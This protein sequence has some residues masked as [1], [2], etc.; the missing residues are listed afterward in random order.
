MHVV[1]ISGSLR[2]KSTSTELLRAA[3]KLVPHGMAI[4]VVRNLDDL[5]HFNPDDDVMPPPEPVEALRS[6]LAGADGVVV[7]CPEYAHGIPGVLKNA[8]DWLV[9]SGELYDKPCALFNPSPRAHHAQD[10]LAEVLRTMGAQIVEP[11]ALAVPLTGTSFDATS[12]VADASLAEP[13]RK[14]LAEIASFASRWRN[15]VTS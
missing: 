4:T 11:A 8:L 15:R 1:A 6:L 3:A 10:A 13:I 9:S 12:I 5:P 2:R 7:A 14:A